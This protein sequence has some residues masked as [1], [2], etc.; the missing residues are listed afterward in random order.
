M[1]SRSGD[2]HFAIRKGSVSE[3][4]MSLL[5]HGSRVCRRGTARMSRVRDAASSGVF[6][7]ERGMH[8]IRLRKGAAGRAEDQRVWHG[9]KSSSGP[10]SGCP[11]RT[12]DTQR[13]IL[14]LAAF[15]PFSATG[16]T[17]RSSARSSVP[18]ATDVRHGGASSSRTS[19]PGSV[20]AI[21]A[22][23]RY[24]RDGNHQEPPG[25]RAPGNFS[26]NFRSAQFLC[27]VYTES[28]FPA[29]SDRADLLL[30][31]SRELDLG[32]RGSLRRQQGLRRSGVHLKTEGQ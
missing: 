29:L 21:A 32:H 9:I 16:S 22:T 6:R 11:C 28:S 1:P 10:R 30:W 14:D 8:G 15:R 20:R 25:L 26:R 12:H 31:S 18:A 5:P 27:R 3:S 4:G 23:G 7:G 13:R 24:S 19:N 17:K 2:M